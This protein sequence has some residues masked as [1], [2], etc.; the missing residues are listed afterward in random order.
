M[1]TNRPSLQ[2]RGFVEEWRVEGE[3]LLMEEQLK[4]MET[5]MVGMEGW[6]SCNLD[7][8]EV[9]ALIPMNEV[10][11]GGEG[12]YWKWGEPSPF[13]SS[14]T[15]LEPTILQYPTPS[16]LTEDSVYQLCSS[17]LLNSSLAV[18]CG[19]YFRSTHISQ[20]L[21]ICTLDVSL[22]SSPSWAPLALSLLA[23]QCHE[24]LLLNSLSWPLDV[25]GRL[26]VP[27]KAVMEITRV[28]LGEVE[29]ELVY[30]EEQDM[31]TNEGEM[32]N[33]FEEDMF[34]HGVYSENPESSTLNVDNVVHTYEKSMTTHDQQEEV[35]SFIDRPETTTV[36]DSDNMVSSEAQEKKTC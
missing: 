10:T 11:K 27:R 33:S 12:K 15:A 14:L 16:G 6:Q 23:L 1:F 5:A 18:A 34:T 31:P 24:S 9:D 30:S 35:V 29:D 13:A 26:V 8:K 2:V 17:T 20:A 36:D 21:D 4:G 7:D 28:L 19:P 32:F 22:T 25:N 3:G